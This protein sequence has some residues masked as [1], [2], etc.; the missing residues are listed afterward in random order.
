MNMLKLPDLG[1]GIEQATVS[2]WYFEVGDR[3]KEG[4][5]VV[6]LVTDKA[7]FNVSA[8]Y[9]GVLKQKLAQQGDDVKIG[10][11]LAIIE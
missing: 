1:E 10:G 2:A 6:E 3:V 7:T 9:S 4:D 5:D 8:A 11:F